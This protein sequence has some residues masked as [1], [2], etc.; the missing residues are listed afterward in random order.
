MARAFSIADNR[1]AE[2]ATWDPELLALAL[3]DADGAGLLD[4]TA[5]DQFGKPLAPGDLPALV[6]LL[7]ELPWSA[8]VPTRSGVLRGD[9]LAAIRDPSTDATGARP[10][11]LRAVPRPGRS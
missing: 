4:A 6:G 10:S 8:V 1:S 5:F 9:G 7:R 11:Y 3:R 2:Q